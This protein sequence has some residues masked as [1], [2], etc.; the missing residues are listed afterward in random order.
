VNWPNQTRKF[1]GGFEVISVTP[2]IAETA[3]AVRKQQKLTLPDA[4]FYATALATGRTLV[5]YNDRDFPQVTP[6]VHTPSE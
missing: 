4:I 2:E 6:S 5:T 1:L 3:V